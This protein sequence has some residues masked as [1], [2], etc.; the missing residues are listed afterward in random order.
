MT[1]TTAG[2]ALVAVLA[3]GWTSTAQEQAGAIEAAVARARAALTARQLVKANQEAEDA[4]HLAVAALEEARGAD[5]GR[6]RAALGDAIETR[7]SIM[8]EDGARA[9]AVRFL[10]VELETNRGSSIQRQLQ[11]VVDRVNLEGRPGP[12]LDRG[13]HVGP[14][15]PSVDELKGKVVLLFFWAH[16]CGQCKADGPIVE[17]LLGKYRGQGLAI[18]APTQRYGYVE[19][20]RPAAPARELQHIVNTRDRHYGFLRK[21]PVPIGEANYKD[22]GVTTIPMYVLLDRQ[23]IVRLYHAGQMTEEELEAAIRRLL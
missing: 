1:T 4:Y 3:G 10:R 17:K 12:P 16:W 8:V 5:A 21:E 19:S 7:A 11:A 14:R 22:Y 23:G 6:I 15:V 13:M 9:E 2:L 20:G 18:V